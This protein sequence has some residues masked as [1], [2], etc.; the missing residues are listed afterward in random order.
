MS[1]TF[2]EMTRIFQSNNK[3]SDPWSN[4]IYH[5]AEVVQRAVVDILSKNWGMEIPIIRATGEATLMKMYRL[6]LT[7]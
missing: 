1:F 7:K 2:G 3:S 4:T 5:D 6:S